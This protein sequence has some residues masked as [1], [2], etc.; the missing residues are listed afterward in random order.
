MYY[1]DFQDLKLSGLG[2][3][4]MRLPVL[5]DEKH[6]I[7]EETTARMLDYCLKNGINYF[8]TAWPYHDGNSE[9][10]V[11]NILSNYPRDSF[12]LATKFPTFD[13]SYFTRYEEVFNKQLEKCKVDY[14]DFYLLHNVSGHNIEFFMDPELGGKVIEYLL[15]QKEEGRIRHFGF[16]SHASSEE[17]VQ[18]L[19]KYG[20]RMEFCQIQLNW[21]DWEYQ[22]AKFKVDELNKRG[23][24]IWV[25]EPVRGGKLINYTAPYIDELKKVRPDD[26]I[27]DWCFKFLR[28]VPGVTMILSG[29]SNEEQLHQNVATFENND[30]LS[31][32]EIKFLFGIKDKILESKLIPCTACRYCT[33]TC[34][35]ELDIPR[36]I[37]I[38]NDDVI[39]EYA[40]STP[41]AIQRLGDGKHPEDCLQCHACESQCPQNIAIPDILEMLVKRVEDNPF[42]KRKV[43]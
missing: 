18:F 26:E 29:M 42:S 24:P 34:P 25:M 13:K 7:D 41:N 21:F 19:D 43:T 14:F 39:A 38:Y 9:I 28:T 15:K 17:F 22:D 11:G 37:E 35:Q 8:D 23:I 36:M 16:S 1:N 2:M 30:K 10:V 27:T 32:D 12:Y 31:E 5:D 20:E 6:S 4:N 33:D 3:G 40:F